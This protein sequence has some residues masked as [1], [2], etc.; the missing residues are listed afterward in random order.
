MVRPVEIVASGW[1]IAGNC[2]AGGPS[3]VSPF[4]FRDRVETAHRVGYCGIGFIHADVVAVSERLG[5]RTMKQI[6][7]D[8]DMK[9]V[10]VEIIGD[11]FTDGEKRRRSDMVRKDLL[12]AAEALGACHIKIGGDIENEG[13]NVYPMDRMIRELKVLATEA[14]NA[15]TKL[16]L[17]LMPFTNLGTIEQGVELIQGTGAKNAGLMLDIWHLARGNIDF[18]DIRTVPRESIFWVEIDDALPEVEGTLYNDTI[19]NRLYPGE[20]SLDIQKFLRTV[21]ATGYDNPFGVEILSREHRSRPLA[22]AAE[23]AYASAMRQFEMLGRPA[24][25]ASETGIG[26]GSR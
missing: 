6:L 9:Y 13:R 1:T 20:G 18:A 11:W 10:E 2:Y 21:Q 16:A 4:D 25:R 23:L 22:E 19:H 14:A 3:E 5:F 12:R 8:N 26:G 17:E 7:D 15:G 24:S